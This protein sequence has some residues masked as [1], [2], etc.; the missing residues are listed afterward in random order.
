MNLFPLF[1]TPIFKKHFEFEPVNLQET[2]D[3]VF[4][5]KGFEKLR[6]Y[7]LSC[8]GEYFYGMMKVNPETGIY[9]TKSVINTRD[10][11]NRN[12]ILTGL[13][14]LSDGTVTFSRDHTT[15]QFVHTSKNEFNSN[16]FTFKVKKGDYIVFPSHLNY[17]TTGDTITWSTF[18]YNLVNKYLFVEPPRVFG[19]QVPEWELK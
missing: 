13:I 16:E 3:V 6:E 10:P 18:V 1:A 4:E 17:V 11:P 19:K 2:S 15:F 12:S 14:M 9:I 7:A 5:E 8:T